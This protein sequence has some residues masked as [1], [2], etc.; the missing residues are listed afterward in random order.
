MKSR[1]FFL[2]LL[3]LLWVGLAEAS[4]DFMSDIP[5]ETVAHLHR[6][7]EDASLTSSASIA[8]Q[9]ALIKGMPE[10]FRDKAKELIPFK[11]APVE[12]SSPKVTSEA[13][14][15]AAKDEDSDSP[16]SPVAVDTAA[17]TSFYTQAEMI[18]CITQFCFPTAA[19]IYERGMKALFRS[20][21]SIPHDAKSMTEMLQCLGS[22]MLFARALVEKVGFTA[23]I[24]DSLQMAPIYQMLKMHSK[25]LREQDPE[26][27]S[28]I[29]TKIPGC[30]N[31]LKLPKIVPK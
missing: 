30:A 18:A 15:L 13:A 23:A 11:E 7:Q 5:P 20:G 25:I 14:A 24:G 4:I 27:W 6:F 19:S 16:R 29:P 26:L 3:S 9:L 12:H 2:S 22:K 28:E 10:Y 21:A 1:V 17:E 8:E 31:C